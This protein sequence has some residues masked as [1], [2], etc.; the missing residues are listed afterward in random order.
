MTSLFDACQLGP[1]RLEHR[2]VMA[3]L[4]RMRS[5]HEAN[6]TALMAE[7]YGQRASK[8]GLLISEATVISPF[9]F[10]HHQ[11]PAVYTPS[12]IENW[13]ETTDAVH[14]KG[15]LIYLQLWHGGRA[16]HPKLQPG[17]RPPPAPSAITPEGAGSRLPDSTQVPFEQPRAMTID[18]VRST[19]VDYV[20]ATRNAM[21]AG[22]DGVE[23][24][25]ANGY[26]PDQFLQDGSN[27]RTDA[28][29]GPIE[30]RARFLIE[31]VDACA[32]VIGIDKMGVRISPQNPFNG[33]SDSD[34]ETTFGY[35]AREMD[36]RKLGYLHVIEPR[37]RGNVDHEVGA[38][39]VAARTL[40][41]EFSGTLM[42]AGGFTRDTGNALIA[43][44]GADLVAYGRHF[45]SNPDLPERFRQN[46][47]LTAYDRSTFY[48]GDETGYT[49]YP[50]AT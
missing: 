6:P 37:V 36:A 35:V 20:T 43:E 41:S 48:G 22:F 9:G 39:P 18:E 44:G 32:E 7:H 26:L 5:F 19:V 21:D 4:T 49:S 14:A 33:V 38:A 1:Y 50:A 29:G 2:V 23:V 34:P 28:Y 13:R 45:I 17:E 8:G 12:Q 30:N 24:H 15:G 40:R 27:H 25:S 46:I 47:E 3:P 16:S 42:A 11:V 31:I 10:P